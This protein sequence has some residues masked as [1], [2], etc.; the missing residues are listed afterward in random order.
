MHVARDTATS[1]DSP[2]DVLTVQAGCTQSADLSTLLKRLIFK[3]VRTK[4]QYD[5]S[6]KK[7][8]YRGSFDIIMVTSVTRQHYSP[9]KMPHAPDGHTTTLATM[10]AKHLTIL[11]D[12]RHH[13]PLRKAHFGSNLKYLL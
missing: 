6:F 11:S 1:A 2:P 4:V 9:S 13:I 5:D 10:C 12:H 7:Y 3:A 8:A